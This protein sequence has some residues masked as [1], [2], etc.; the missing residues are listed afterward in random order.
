MLQFN[1]TV[2]SEWV[3]RQWETVIYIHGWIGG[4]ALAEVMQKG[5]F[6]FKIFFH[7]IFF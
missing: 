7:L 2:N 1:S 4:H 6:Q 3:N 5:N